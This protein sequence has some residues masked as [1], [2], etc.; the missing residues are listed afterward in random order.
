M[1]RATQFV[2]VVTVLFDLVCCRRSLCVTLFS[3][4]MLIHCSMYSIYRLY[5]HT[6]THKISRRSPAR[7]LIYACVLSNSH[8]DRFTI[9]FL[10]FFFYSAFVLFCCSKTNS[11]SQS[12]HMIQKRQN[13]ML[14][15]LCFILAACLLFCVCIQLMGHCD[16]AVHTLD[17]RTFPHWM[18][19][20]CPDSM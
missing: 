20:V 2:I 5:S 7:V 15:I 6:A 17:I 8:T 9:F 3:S 13:K 1:Y 19:H 14:L 11:V 16:V 18:Y 10:P 4:P 12:V